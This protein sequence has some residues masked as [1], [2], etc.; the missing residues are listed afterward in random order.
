MIRSI[1]LLGVLVVGTALASPAVA[2]Q[3]NN[4]PPGP[5]FM[6]NVIAFDAGNCPAGDFTDSNRHMIAVQANFTPDGSG[7]LGSTQAGKDKNDIIKINTIKL[8]QGPD[9]QVLDGNACNKDSAELMLPADPFA[10]DGDGD[11]VLDAVNDPACIGENLEF[12][13]YRVFIRLV[14]RL[15]TGI[16]VTTCADE[17]IDIDGD[18]VIEDTV[19]CSTENVVRV[20]AAGSKFE[21]VTRQL[22]T[23]CLDTD[24]SGTCD[25]RLGIFDQALSDVFWQWNTSGK[26]HA[27]LVFVPQ[28][29]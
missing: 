1:Q 17:A 28:P 22:L 19:I 18:G 15:D 3:G 10:C 14:G 25:T 2:G 11:G 9:I 27:Q 26:A 12:Q 29:D 16:G 13:E 20:R 23:L 8:T 6:L 24:L 4:L 21:D 5:H 7:D